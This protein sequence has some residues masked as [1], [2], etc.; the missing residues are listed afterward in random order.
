MS[1]NPESERLQ[2]V[3]EALRHTELHI[4]GL[5]DL[6][7][8]ADRRSTSFFAGGLTFAGLL[9]ASAQFFPS[10][11]TS[12]TAAIICIVAAIVSVFSILPKRFHI[13]GHRWNDW[14]DHVVEGDSLIDVLISQAEENDQ[15]IIHNFNV[16]DRS[17]RRFL[18]TVRLL[19]FAFIIMILGQVS[20]NYGHC[21]DDI[22]DDIKIDQDESPTHES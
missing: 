11:V 1:E 17:A 8:N 16:L 18:W 5:E 21:I 22:I 20:C 7:S 10:T 12:I 2:V 13:L 4:K 3:K 15:R 6:A 9:I 14:K 19:I